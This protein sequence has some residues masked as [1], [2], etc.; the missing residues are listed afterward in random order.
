MSGPVG[1]PDE[2]ARQPLESVRPVPNP[3]SQD[4][5]TLR[6]KTS[7]PDVHIA[8]RRKN[9]ERWNDG[10]FKGLTIGVVVAVLAVFITIAVMA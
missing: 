1:T 5:G 3:E 10:F 8:C 4:E 7:M 2:E 9:V 6:W